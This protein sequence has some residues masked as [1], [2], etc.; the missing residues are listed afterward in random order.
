MRE[1]KL[2]KLS[3]QNYKNIEDAQLQ[4]SPRVNC[5][6]GDNGMG[7]T[8]ILDA[9][10]YLSFCKS[11]MNL[12]DS[13]VMN[14]DA[15][16]MMLQGHYTRRDVDED[17]SISMQRGKRKIARRGG[18]EYKRLSNHI[19]LLPL[20]MISPIDVDLIR[21]SGEVRR[22]FIDQIISQTD[23]GYLDA[24]IRYTKA[25]EQRN[26]MI[27]QRFTDALLYETVEQQ[28]CDSGTYIHDVRHRWIE[29]FS[30]IFMRYYA[31]IAGENEPVEMHYNSHLADASMKCVLDESRSRD[32]ILGHTS[33]G[34]H[35]DDIELMLGEH[36]M[37]KTGSQGQC[38]TYTVAL[39]LAQF[40][41]LKEAN[42][43]TPILL[44]DDIFDKLDASRVESI[45][46]VVSNDRFGQI[47][48]TDTNRD[49]LNEIIARLKGDNA[50][51]TVKN[52]T[53]T[54]IVATGG[55]NA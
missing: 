32:M 46:E 43:T 47:F 10:Y 45:M 20:V 8:N 9:I 14:H 54:P 55:H 48:I 31:A 30:P 11:Y 4:F 22:R 23:T 28:M 33:R 35:R 16:Y 17:I 1:M 5:L 53:L 6:I 29:Q 7:K 41:F 44:L 26:S 21:G 12:S 37:R 15:Q 42:A 49:H 38:K 2:N 36:S 19:G 27:K 18:K 39:R 13:I 51:F 24:L 52:G 3:I 34:V 40:E 25:V 50:M